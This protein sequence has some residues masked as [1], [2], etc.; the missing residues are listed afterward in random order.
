M[1]FTFGK[2]NIDKMKIDEDEEYAYDKH[3][4]TAIIEK[5]GTLFVSPEETVF[6]QGEKADRIYYII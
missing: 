4:L 5:M 2:K 3:L 6:K 1:F